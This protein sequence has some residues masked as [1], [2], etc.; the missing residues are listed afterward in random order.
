MEYVLLVVVGVLL[1]S[2]I[3]FALLYI[4]LPKGKRFKTSDFL[5]VFDDVEANQVL[6]QSARLVSES[7]RDY[8][9]S[10]DSETRGATQAVL[11]DK[12]VIHILPKRKLPQYRLNGDR[13]VAAMW[14]E[15]SSAFRVRRRPVIIVV[16]ERIDSARKFG[17]LVIHEMLHGLSSALGR[18]LDH[19]HKDVFLWY[20]LRES[21]TELYT[22]KLKERGY[23]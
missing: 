7:F 22:Q 12:P 2:G 18:G 17:L 23:A 14:T 6:V 5:I 9:E 8:A 19:Q 1:V 20:D 10:A 4:P 21:V 15:V 13:A 16:W 3:L 11:A